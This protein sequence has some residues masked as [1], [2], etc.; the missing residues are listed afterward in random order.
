MY[1]YLEHKR[2]KRDEICL[3]LWEKLQIAIHKQTSFCSLALISMALDGR[4]ETLT[5]QQ[6][7]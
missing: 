2:T 1:V 5:L 6:K 4:V 3:D 7:L